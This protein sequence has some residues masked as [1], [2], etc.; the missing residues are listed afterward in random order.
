VHDLVAVHSQDGRAQ[1]VL[2]LGVDQHLHEALRFAGFAGAAHALHR[3]LG[4][5]HAA[6]AGAGFGLGDA[7][8][9]ERRVDEERVA[10]YAVADAARVVVEQVG[11]HDLVVVPRRVREGAAAVAVAH[12]PHAFGTGAA[13]LVDLDVAARVGLDAGHR[14]PQA[15]GVRAPA[16]GQQHV[17]ADDARLAAS[18]GGTHGN[19]L[20]FGGQRQAFGAELEAHAFGLQDAADAVGDVGVLAR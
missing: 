18:T 11:D 17:A 8:A 9:A 4:V 6:A 7:D 14:Q 13:L 10:G 12:R 1:Q 19:A 2:V 3:H 5:Q 15:V 20:A 16:D